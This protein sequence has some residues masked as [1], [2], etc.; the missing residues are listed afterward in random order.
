[1]KVGDKLRSLDGV[2]RAEVFRLDRSGNVELNTFN[3]G[4][5]MGEVRTRTD[6]SEL[7]MTY[8]NSRRGEKPLFWHRPA[9]HSRDFGHPWKSAETR[10]HRGRSSA[11]QSVRFRAS[12][13]PA[14]RT[15]AKKD[16][17]DYALELRGD[18][19]EQF[20]VLVR[21]QGAY[22]GG[23]AVEV[24]LE[25]DEIEHP[26]NAMAKRWFRS[27][28]GDRYVMSMLFAVG[29]DEYGNGR[30]SGEAFQVEAVPRRRGRD[31]TRTRRIRRRRRC[32]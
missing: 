13:H 10:A 8:G 5:L 30:S 14:I 7:V 4:L 1:M 3:M 25:F 32:R 31:Q 29:Y 16:T 20:V 12:R 23:D 15:L 22:A 17:G 26:S 28:R 9:G 24:W 11:A 18:G 6:G 27:I 21:Y 19:V 2:H